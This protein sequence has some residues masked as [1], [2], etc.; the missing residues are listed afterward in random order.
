MCNV[1]QRTVDEGEL[2]GLL[3]ISVLVFGLGQHV[4]ITIANV[5]MAP[6]LM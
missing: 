1:R 3:A 5:Y 4:Q 2:S 6:G